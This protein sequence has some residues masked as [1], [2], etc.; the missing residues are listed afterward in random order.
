MLSRRVRIKLHGG[1]DQIL[2]PG[3]Q[4]SGFVE[5]KSPSVERL[6]ALTID[7][8]GV[9]RVTPRKGSKFDREH[10]ELFH[11]TERLLREPMFTEGKKSHRWNFTFS[12]PI[13][14][15]PD[16]STLL[17]S[18]SGNLLFDE[19]PHHL[20]PSL[21]SDQSDEVSIEYQMYAV[22]N[23]AFRGYGAT[24]QL[25]D[26]PLVHNLDNICYRPETESFRPEAP[27]ILEQ[28]FQMYPPRQRKFSLRS[29]SLGDASQSPVRSF[30]IIASLPVTMALGESLPVTF[31]IKQDSARA[32]ADGFGDSNPY[33]LKQIYL[34]LIAHTHRRTA[35]AAHREAFTETTVKL[36]GVDKSMGTLSLDSAKTRDV[37]T[38]KILGYPPTFKS[39]SIS[40]AYELQL[41]ITVVCEKQVFEARF[42]EP[43]KAVHVLSPE[44]ELIR[45][46]SHAPP[47]ALPYLPPRNEDEALPSYGELHGEA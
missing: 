42:T 14:T 3:A 32:A 26:E 28:R 4:V 41:D 43:I 21:G 12:M 24:E 30:T 5:Y 6:T 33:T 39:Y 7:F 20:P 9:S 31:Q 37:P 17:Y 22:A 47:P 38:S 11:I 29:P 13:F 16:R 36:L 40:R 45:R 1:N 34:S 10:I 8:R 25:Q 19:K 23:R 35:K 2:Y 18:D 27:R 46:E 44:A 15:G